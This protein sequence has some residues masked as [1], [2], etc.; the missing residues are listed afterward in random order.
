MVRWLERNG[1]DV[2]YFTGVDG[3]RRGA[4]ILEHRAFLSVGHDEYW[5]GAQR[6]NVEAARDAGTSLAFFSGNEVFWKTRWEDGHRTMVC[7]K[8]THAGA[9]I[10]PGSWTGTWRDSRPFNPEGGRPENALTGTWF[11]VNS[12]TRAITVPAA[13]GDLRFWRGTSVANLAPGTT[14]TLTAD[15][16]GY[17]WDSAP[18][19]GAAPAGLVRMSST[20]A[21]GV[22]VLQDHGSTY[23]AGTATHNLTLYRDPNGARRDA[24]VFG[25]GTI[26]WPWGLDDVHERGSPPVSPAMQQATANLLADMGAQPA[27][28]QSDLQ[29]PTASTDT[30]PPTNTLDGPATRRV[31]A[32]VPETIH[33]TASD[34]GGGVV[35]A[36]EVSVDGGASWHPATGRE[37]WSFTWTPTQ[38]GDVTPVARAT[39]DSGNLFGA[40]QAS[41]AEP[42]GATQPTPLATR[43]GAAGRPARPKAPRRL[44]VSHAGIVRLRVSCPAGGRACRVSV[45]LRRQ[46]RT[47]AG[48]KRTVKPGRTSAIRLRLTR[49][50][51]RELVRRRSLAVTAVTTVRGRTTQTPIRLVAPPRRTT[52]TPIRLVAPPRS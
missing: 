26:Q 11:S 32:G 41:G 38:S 39:D 6:A 3:D 35:G 13:D 23:G 29:P 21:S 44:R 42:T 2:S 16:L 33:G 52:Q 7:F 17:E 46:G 50:A 31:S 36:V 40:D 30:I 19:N 43:P 14:A 45:R 51:R 27:T 24:L 12:G 8:E 9:K 5:S 28:L 10:D 15:T 34:T 25:A 1:Y 47:I 48:A 22:E 37:Q 49:A 20:T 4:E 18:D